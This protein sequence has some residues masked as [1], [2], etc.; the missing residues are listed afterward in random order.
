MQ[1]AS[2]HPGCRVSILTRAR[3]W[4]RTFEPFHVFGGR[5]LLDA[6][7]PRSSR[8]GLPFHLTFDLDVADPR[9]GGLGVTS[10]RRLAILA[11][12]HVEYAKGGV[13]LVRH[14]DK[15]AR[16]EI[17]REPRGTL[18]P[19]VPE[20]LP[21]LPVEFEPLSEADVAVETIDELPDDH[22]P[23]HQVGGHPTWVTKALLAPLCPVTRRRMRYVATVDSV[24]RFPLGH[25]DASLQFGD[26][27]LC[28]VF[29]SD[30][31]SISAC[32]ID[33]A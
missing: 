14:H 19:G 16:L 13:L 1:P 2:P 26:P 30:E 9:V 29:W 28:H 25:G 6:A 22:G 20:E 15:G 3:D 31:A 17:L 18:L 8:C 21:Q 33:R 32:L 23:L 12:F 4:K 27:G 11:S 10:V 5:P 24:R 7:L